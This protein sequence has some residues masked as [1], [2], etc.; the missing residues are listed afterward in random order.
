M[1]N[2]HMYENYPDISSINKDKMKSHEVLHIVS[3]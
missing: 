1:I 2:D 3:A